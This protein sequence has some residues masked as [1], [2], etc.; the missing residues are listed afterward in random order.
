MVHHV[1]KLAGLKYA[2]GGAR[3]RLAYLAQKKWLEIHGL[4]LEQEFQVDMFTIVAMFD[5]YSGLYPA[6]ALLG[7]SAWVTASHIIF[8]KKSISECLRSTRADGQKLLETRTMPDTSSSP[9]MKVPSWR[10]VR[11]S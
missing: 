1:Q 6:L 7:R 3:E 4:D 5:A 2:C 9:L 10:A 11:R 8:C